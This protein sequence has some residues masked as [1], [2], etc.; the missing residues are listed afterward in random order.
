MKK[1]FIKEYDADPELLQDIAMETKGLEYSEYVTKECP[2]QQIGFASANKGPQHDEA[3]M[4]SVELF[5][6]YVPTI[7]EK[8]DAILEMTILRTW[9]G[10]TGVCKLLWND[11]VP[12]DNHKQ[13]K[14]YK[15][16]EHVQ[17]YVELFEAMTGRE[18]TEKDI[19]EQSERMHNF[20]RVFNIRLG[21]SGREKDRPPYRAVGPVTIEEYLFKEDFYD[22]KVKE[23]AGDKVETM[24]IKEKMQTLREYREEFYE[25]LLS[26]VY[27]CRGWD[28]NGIPKIET[29]KR[30]NIDYPDV[31]KI[32][33]NA[34]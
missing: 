23:I 7:K 16:P 34:K 22:E 25:K 14:P 29:L 8:A 2:T 33:E 26:A 28:E 27:E 17:N 6:N 15:I 32:V 4:F 21:V 19:M 12:E 11:I 13:D 3:L 24:D 31:V 1:Y 20:Q 5:K 18:T 10:L 30:L 9:F